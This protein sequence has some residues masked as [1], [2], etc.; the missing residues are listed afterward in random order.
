M[1]NSII[2]FTVRIG[3]RIAAVEVK[4]KLPLNGASLSRLVN[5]VNNMVAWGRG[6]AVVWT[7]KE[8]TLAEIRKVTEAIGANSGRVQF[9][10]G[11]E[12]LAKWGELYFG[13]SPAK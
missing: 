8:P 4:Y 9:V 12:G 1:G 6:Q 7:L 5:Q 2:D 11:V 13:L 3:A 10:S